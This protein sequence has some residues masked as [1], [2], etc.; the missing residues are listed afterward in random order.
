MAVKILDC[1]LRDGGYVND[2]NFGQDNINTIITNLKNLD[3][4]LIEIGFCKGEGGNPN[5]AEYKNIHEINSSSIQHNNLVVMVESGY[6]FDLGSIPE[7]CISKVKM[8]YLLTYKIKNYQ[9]F[10]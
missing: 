8:I 9:K 6:K 4:D 1:T 10:F 7:S 2:W 3:I 5:R